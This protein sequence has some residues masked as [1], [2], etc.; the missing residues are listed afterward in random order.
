MAKEVLKS[1]AS[2]V[3][4]HESGD[5]Y[6]EAYILK[7]YTICEFNPD[8]T[9]YAYTKRDDL[10]LPSLIGLKPKNLIL[11][12]SWDGIRSSFWWDGAI[13][14]DYDFKTQDDEMKRQGFDNV[15]Y[16]TDQESTCNFQAHNKEEVKCM[17]GCRKCITS[18][19]E[20][21]LIKRH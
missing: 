20:P 6:S 4:V 2:V 5:F 16:V 11:I 3:H 14:N 19:D 8:V 9:F 10:F 18:F 15:I 13:R 17:D 7:W 21:L 12:Y 1:K